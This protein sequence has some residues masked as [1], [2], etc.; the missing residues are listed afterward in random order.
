MLGARREKLGERVDLS[1]PCVRL[2]KEFDSGVE[3]LTNFYRTSSISCTPPIQVQIGT[4]IASG[5]TQYLSDSRTPLREFPQRDR[6]AEKTLFNL[7]CQP[8][9]TKSR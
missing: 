3:V 9:I 4:V 8:I 5:W 6:T 2:D 1:N 7:L